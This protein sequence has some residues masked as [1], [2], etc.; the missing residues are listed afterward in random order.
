ME[1]KQQPLLYRIHMKIKVYKS[2]SNSNIML[3]TKDIKYFLEFKKKNNIYPN[4]SK[5]LSL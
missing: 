3:A 2:P 5:T 4:M 1:G